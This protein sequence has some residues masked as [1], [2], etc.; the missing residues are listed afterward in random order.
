MARLRRHP[1]VGRGGAA[2]PSPPVALATGADPN[3]QG[4]SGDAA[5]GTRRL[6][7]RPA[8]S[9][10]RRGARPAGRP[11]GPLRGCRAWPR[12]PLGPGGRQ[13][14]SAATPARRPPERRGRAGRLDEPGLNRGRQLGH[15]GEHRGGG[16]GSR[17]GRTAAAGG[18]GA[19][20]APS[21]RP[22]WHRGRGDHRT[23]AP[24]HVSSPRRCS[25]SVAKI[26]S[27]TRRPRRW[28][29]H[30]RRPPGAAPR[31]WVR[32]P[33]PLA[34][35]LDRGAVDDQAVVAV[36]ARGRPQEGRR[37]AG[38]QVGA[39]V[40]AHAGDEAVTLERHGDRHDVGTLVV[41]HGRQVG[42][43]AELGQAVTQGLGVH[44]DAHP[45]SVRLRPPAP[46]PRRPATAPRDRGCLRRSDDG[47]TG[48][49]L[50]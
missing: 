17:A 25:P 33:A 26:V 21:P 8:R 31:G 3:H 20:A 11:G 40:A 6:G 41:G 12:R 29:R 50:P 19:V 14:R 16:R 39:G 1:A 48:Q 36:A 13:A 15:R 7:P 27:A 46:R 37:R 28:A 10:M 35:R 2:D 22:P 30:P 9:R 4:E 23:Q 47:V 18:G 49:P 5:P 44:G 32:R 34:V 45:R 24:H 42:V 43:G 38:G